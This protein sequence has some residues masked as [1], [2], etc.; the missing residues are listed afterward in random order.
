MNDVIYSVFGG[1]ILLLMSGVFSGL[2]L[3]LLSL[4]PVSLEKVARG[5]TVN[6]KFAQIILRTEV[7]RFTILFPE[8]FTKAQED[9]A[10]GLELSDIVPDFTARI[11]QNSRILRISRMNFIKCLEGK[12]RNYKGPP[13]TAEFNFDHRSGKY[14]MQSIKSCQECQGLNTGAPGARNLKIIDSGSHM[15]DDNSQTKYIYREQMKFNSNPSMENVPQSP[16]LTTVNENKD[17]VFPREEIPLEQRSPSLLQ[18][19]VGLRS[20]ESDEGVI[21]EIC[22]VPPISANIRVVSDSNSTH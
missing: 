6:A 18:Q 10:R 13:K 19:R 12:L 2:T 9:Y 16:S 7:S 15:I 22:S 11:I 20:S 8:I 3:G 21:D 5:D 17:M 14:S 4:D 1:V